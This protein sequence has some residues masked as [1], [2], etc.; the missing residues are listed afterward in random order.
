MVKA[1]NAATAPRYAYNLVRTAPTEVYTTGFQARNE[2]A[3]ANQ[4]T[5]TAVNFLSVA[6]FE[7]K[8]N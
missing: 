5:G 8:V 1:S 2:M 7:S 3:R 6:R 4:F